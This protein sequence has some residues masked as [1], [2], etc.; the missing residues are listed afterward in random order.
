M[1]VPYEAATKSDLE[2]IVL[3]GNTGYFY[4]NGDIYDQLKGVD[5]VKN[6]SAQYY[7]ASASAGCCSIPVQII[8]Y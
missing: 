1:V 5:G 6:I 8:G 3:Q 7:L 4:M 2:N